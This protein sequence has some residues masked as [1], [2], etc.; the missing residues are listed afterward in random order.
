LLAELP[1]KAVHVENN[2][3]CAAIAEHR[4][5]AAQNQE[6]FLYLQI[7]VKIGAGIVVNGKVLRG[8]HG[9][10]GELAVMPFP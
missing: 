9:G 1:D 3:N 10:A 6:L 2:V 5:G 8:S 7:G 4:L